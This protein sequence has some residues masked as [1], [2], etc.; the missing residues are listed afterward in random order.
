M[1]SSCGGEA[2]GRTRLPP[3]ALQAAESHAQL[4]ADT[5]GGVKLSQN[6]PSRPRAAA[7]RE[8]REA[9]HPA[10]HANVEGQLQACGWQ[11]QFG[12]G[13]ISRQGKG[14]WVRTSGAQ[15]PSESPPPCRP[16]APPA[17]VGLH[18]PKRQPVAARLLTQLGQPPALAGEHS[19]LADAGAH[20]QAHA[21]QDAWGAALLEVQLRAVQ[22]NPCNETV[23]GAG[24]GQ[25]VKR[26]WK[27]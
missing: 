24:G 9:Q 11:A 13:D 21:Q 3:I 2:A 14:S 6:Q 23:N 16:S 25:T 26:Q 20:Q 10:R 5:T 27:S 12:L 1:G 19:G 18:A 22:R 17:P 7:H 4:A 15:A 8:Q